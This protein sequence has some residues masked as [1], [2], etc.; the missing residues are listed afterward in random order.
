MNRY[1]KVIAILLVP[2]LIFTQIPSM[3]ETTD[4]ATTNAVAGSIQEI[5][6]L[7]SQLAESML[8]YLENKIATDHAQNELQASAKDE[9]SNIENG[10]DSPSGSRIS[11]LELAI[12]VILALIILFGGFS[13]PEQGRI[14]QDPPVPYPPLPPLNPDNDSHVATHVDAQKQ[15]IMKQRFMGIVSQVL[16]KS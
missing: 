16:F 6:G 3:A 1:L 8:T 14:N 10:D 7:T 5:N 15:A 9:T 11:A 4:V 12:L 2:C 13:K